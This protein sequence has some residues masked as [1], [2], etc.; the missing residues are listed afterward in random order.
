MSRK[1]S[2]RNSSLGVTQ[3]FLV[4]RVGGQEARHSGRSARRRW[5]NSHRRTCH[6]SSLFRSASSACFRSVMSMKVMTAPRV[7]P[8]RTI[9]WDQNS[10]ER[11]GAILSPINLIVSMDALAFL[12]TYVNGTL[13][14]LDTA[15]RPPGVWCSSAWHVFPEQ[16]S[17]DRRIRA[18]ARLH[19]Y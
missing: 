12:K 5:P 7:L 11:A 10:T 15:C 9:G 8:S 3:H 19:D 13:P 1:V 6:R 18:G 16:F 17:S 2:L 4:R 14:R